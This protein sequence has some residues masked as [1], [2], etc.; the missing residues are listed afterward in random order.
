MT[1]FVRGEQD[2][3]IAEEASQALFSGQGSLDNAPTYKMTAPSMIL[4]DVLFESKL[5][6]SKSEGRRMCQQ[7]A[8][9]VNGNVVKDFAYQIDDKDFEN[10]VCI[11]KKGKKN[12]V[13]V[14]R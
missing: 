12:F 3:K 14:E 9:S 6:T 2:A 13:K 1:K 4:N 8:I 10:G 11:L 7:G 5:V